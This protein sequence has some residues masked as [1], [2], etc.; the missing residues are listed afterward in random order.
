MVEEKT[1]QLVKAYDKLNML[2]ENKMHFLVY[3]SQ[4]IDSSLDRIKNLAEVLLNY[5]AFA[6]ADTQFTKEKI[7]LRQ[8]VNTILKEMENRVSSSGIEL[9]VDVPEEAVV[10]ADRYYLG[11]VVKIMIENALIYTPEGGRVNI[12]SK[13]VDGKMR[14]CVKDTGKGMEHEDLKKVFKP[15]V[16][17]RNKRHKNG[18]G[19]N[20]PLA[21]SI[22]VGHEGRIWA[23]SDGPGSGSS[24]CFELNVSP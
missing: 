18:F 15:F 6:G 11:R 23:E 2:D 7:E 24:F 20:L 19:L 16:I 12:E 3:L 9:D 8:L 1:A 22:I 4:E 13:P 14:F 10:E 5:F 17:E 21:R